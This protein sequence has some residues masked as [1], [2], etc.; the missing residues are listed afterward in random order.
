MVN[1]RPSAATKL[2]RTARR[3]PWL[4]PN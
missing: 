3:N 2:R 4:G 1:G